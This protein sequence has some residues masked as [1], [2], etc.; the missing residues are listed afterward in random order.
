MS[1]MSLADYRSQFPNGHKTKKGRN[2][3]NASKIKFDGMTFDSTKEYNRYIELKAMQQRE[4]VF[5]LEHH[6][7]FELAPSVKIEGEKRT[8]PALRYFADFTYYLINGEY[9]VEDV[10]SVATRKLPSYR[11]KK[12]LMKTVHNIDVREV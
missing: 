6:T 7:K 4:E 8:K 12:H 5:G 11:N 9:I 10:K 3:F 2:K 1:S